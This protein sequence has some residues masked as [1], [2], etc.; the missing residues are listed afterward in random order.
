MMFVI[1]VAFLFDLKRD[2]GVV[3]SVLCTQRFWHLTVT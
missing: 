3:A 2:A 1:C